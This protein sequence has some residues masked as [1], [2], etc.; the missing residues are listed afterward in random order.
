MGDLKGAV[1]SDLLSTLVSTE[2]QPSHIKSFQ[3][4][5]AELCSCRSVEDKVRREVQVMQDIADK[6]GLN[7][8]Q[9]MGEILRVADDENSPEQRAKI[10]KEIDTMTRQ[11]EKLTSWLSSDASQSK[12]FRA[13]CV[14]EAEN[15]LVGIVP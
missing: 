5:R 11:R 7:L 8:A 15:W 13:K 1:K 12:E 14:E 2:Q 3:E 10:Q 6:M 4:L 9:R